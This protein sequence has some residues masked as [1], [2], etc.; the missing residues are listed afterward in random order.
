M[1][2][3]GLMHCNSPKLESVQCVIGYM[4]FFPNL[5]V[6]VNMHMIVQVCSMPVFYLIRWLTRL[7]M[8]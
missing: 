6:Y 5:N 2:V 1:I 7:L 8:W 3:E 4:Y